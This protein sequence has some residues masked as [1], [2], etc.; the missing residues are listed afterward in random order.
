M[1]AINIFSDQKNIEAFVGVA[2]AVRICGMHPHTLRKYANEGKIK[3]YNTP[4]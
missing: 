3:G 1:D 4:S 2:E